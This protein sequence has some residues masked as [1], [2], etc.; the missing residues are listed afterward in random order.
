MTAAVEKLEGREYERV[1][2]GFRSQFEF[3]PGMASCTWPAIKEPAD[4]VTWSL[5]ALDDDL[6]YVKLDAMVDVVNDGLWACTAPGETLLILDWQHDCFRISPHAMTAE[7]GPRW[8]ASVMPDG[9]YNIHLAEDFSYG[10]FGHPW[11]YTICVMGASLLER[12]A[13]HLDDILVWRAREGGQPAVGDR[14]VRA[15]KPPAR[16]FLR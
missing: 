5:A 7:D 11:E 16:L 9:D 15:P 2:K 3:R 10:T 8:P 12:V 4:S 1:W 6:G 14:A 13:S